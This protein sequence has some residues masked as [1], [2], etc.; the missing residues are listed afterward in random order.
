MGINKRAI[1][2]M[3]PRD[4]WRILRGDTV[5][6]DA[7]KDKG[8]TGTVTK[9]LRDEKVPKAVIQGRNLVGSPCSVRIVFVG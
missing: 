4:K 3:F 7:G 9:V 6:I 1:K 8:Q 5:Y 2:A